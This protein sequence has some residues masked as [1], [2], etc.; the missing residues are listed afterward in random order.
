M[1]LTVS[2]KIQLFSGSFDDKSLSVSED[3]SQLEK[4][5]MLVY[6]GKFNSLDGEVEIKDDDIEKLASNHNGMLASLKRLA[7]GDLPIK[8]SPPVQL[9]HSTSAMHTVGRLVGDL[10]VGEHVTSEGNFKALMGTVKILGRENVEKVEDGRW[11]HV[12]IG[13]DLEQHKISELTITPFPAAADA[14][15]LSRFGQRQK[16]INYKKLYYEIW[17]E[18]P[19]GYYAKGQGEIKNEIAV[20]Y[21]DRI[22]EA[23]EHAEMEIDGYLESGEELSNLSKGVSEMSYKEMQERMAQYEKCKKHLTEDKKM[24]EEEVEK[25]L[26]EAKDEDVKKMAEEYD[27]KMSKLAAEKEEEEKKLST[28]TEE[29]EKKKTAMSGHRAKLIQLTKAGKD[30]QEQIKLAQRKVKLSSRLASLKAQAKIAPSEIKKLDLADL[31]KKSDEAIEVALSLYEKREPLVSVGLYG[32]TK[33]LSGTQLSGALKK[34]QMEQLELQTRLNMPSKRD[35]ALKRLTEVQEEMKSME[36][37]VSVHVDAPAGDHPVSE[38]ADYDLAYDSMKKLMDEGKHD[39]AKEHMKSYMKK[40]MSKET[41]SE[42]S[43]DENVEKQLSALAQDIEKLQTG[44]TEFALMIAPLI[45]LDVKE[46]G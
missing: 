10:E 34:L 5:V 21:F 31:A 11:T 22:E 38:L 13:A 24:S 19:K 3:K 18:A 17:Y 43:T 44:T 7:T 14:S 29:E 4:K 26:E 20:S 27:A 15:L 2:K 42:M 25:H 23:Q 16:V 12:S 46:L 37:D 40:V 33:A 39:E 28:D 1:G 6:T 36:G 8:H 9:D 30:S 41:A 35:A 45:G 32:S